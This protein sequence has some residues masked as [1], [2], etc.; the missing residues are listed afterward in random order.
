MAVSDR[1]LIMSGGKIRGIVF[2]EK[3]SIEEIGLKMTGAHQE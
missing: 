1:I 3:T 2:P